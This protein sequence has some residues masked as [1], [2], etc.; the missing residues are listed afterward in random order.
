MSLPVVA[1][2]LQLVL[3]RDCFLAD[4]T[5]TFTRIKF[6][7]AKLTRSHADS[8]S[9]KFLKKSVNIFIF[10]IDQAS[11]N[12]SREK[13]IRSRAELVPGILGCRIN[14]HVI[15]STNTDVMRVRLKKHT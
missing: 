8:I 3:V 15:S 11:N 7:L 5:K 2:V 6:K 9:V 10:Q 12:E 14:V 4:M 13:N 1:F